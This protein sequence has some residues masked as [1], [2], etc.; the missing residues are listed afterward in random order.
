MWSVVSY[1][2]INVH[3]TKSSDIHREYNFTVPTVFLKSV[4]YINVGLM[5]CRN[6]SKICFRFYP[7]PHIL[8]QIMLLTFQ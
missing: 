5:F 7:V 6:T 1:L 8:C 4:F 3:E 2:D